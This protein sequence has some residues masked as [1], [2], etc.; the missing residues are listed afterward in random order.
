MNIK[1]VK[2]EEGI[3]STCW[4]SNITSLENISIV[5]DPGTYKAYTQLEGSKRYDDW[6]PAIR[7][8]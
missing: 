1:V 7:L 4:E 3:E 6:I 5:L 8:E 2:V